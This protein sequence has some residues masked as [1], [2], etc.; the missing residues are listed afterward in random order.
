MGCPDE[1]TLSDFLVGLLPEARRQ[2]VLAHVEGC[3]SCQ[4]A[5][6]AGGD[7]TPTAGVPDV[8]SS[9][10]SE[11]LA[12]GATLSRYV[13]QERLGSGAM[14]VVY[15]AYDPELDRQVAL[16]LLRPEGRGVE[17]LRLRLL[18]E[19]QALARLSHPH[20]VAVHDVGMCGDGVFLALE[21]VDGTTLADWL[22]EPRPWREVLRVFLDAGRGLAAAHAAGL[23][24]RDFKPANVLV[25]RDG[26]ARVTDFGLA[27]PA[28]RAGVLPETSS[29]QVPVPEED[30]LGLLTRTGALLGTPAYMAP[31]QLEGHGVDALSD[32][33]SF[34]V[35]LYEA[36][37]G[38]RPFDG[39]SL[40]ELGQAAREGRVK[41][42]GRDSKVPARVRN[43][44]LRGL[45]PRPEDRFPSMEAL[46]VALTPAPSRVRTW[47]AVSAATACLVGVAMGY[48]VAHRREARCAQEAEKLDAAWGAGRRERVRAAFLATKK[49]YAADAWEK[50]ST[51]LDAHA[52]L[53]RSLRT[54]SCLVADEGASGPASRLAWQ[55]AACLDARLWQ[56]AAVTEVL[57][58]ADAQTVQN[59]PQLVASL[60]G[61]AGCRDAPAS[62]TR[63][64]PPELL[65]P[66]VDAARRKLAE[67]RAL[68]EAGRHAEGNEM[69]SALLQEVDA[70]DYRPLEAEVLLLRG[71]LHGHLGKAK[72]AEDILYRALWAAEAGRDDETVARV[73][74]LLV[75]IVGDQMARVGEAD[76]LAQHARAVVERL[77][78]ERFPAIATDLHLRLGGVRLVQGKLEQA[79]E[80]LTQGL[81][82]A[83]KTYGPDSL[84]TSYFLS[85]L[86][87]VR[88]RQNRTVEALALYRQAQELRERLW[89]SE[90]PA[91][92]LNLSNLATELLSLG[93]REEAVAAWRRALALLEASRPPDH[94][95]LGPPLN[96]LG[97]AL[98]DQGRLDEARQYLKRA[99]AIFE[100]SKG[101]NHPNTATTLSGLGMVAYDSQNLDEALG[102]QRQALERIQSALGPDSPRAA[103][104]LMY[105]GV[106]QHRMGHHDEARRHLLRALHLWEKEN[107]PDSATV[108]NALRPLARLELSAGAPQKALAYCKRALG[109]DE[110]AQGTETPDVAMDLACVAEAHLALGDPEQAVPLLERARLLNAKAPRDPLDEAWVSFLLARALGEREPAVELARAA[111]LA[112]EA[113]VRM[114]AL[115]TRARLELKEVTAWQERHPAPS[116]V[117]RKAV[118]P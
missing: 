91:L 112:E 106:V 81:E 88:S 92:A 48:V 5:L 30:S 36:L 78:R 64:Q 56:F 18:R 71:Q 66:R 28:S 27:R 87:R 43:A 94:A 77:G 70:L 9:G 2:E 72:E 25:G 7:S 45:R 82:L 23:V 42:P 57:E 41:A 15:A 29:A 102:Y 49:P 16:K 104:P 113:R 59:V 103:A 13:V 73:W 24:H 75:W 65:R 109:N 44:V 54:E 17:E 31:E 118:T 101:P 100:R 52:S 22:K 51:A 98:R 10:S 96:N 93:R 14:G 39:L 19:A 55:T 116:S 62:S 58:K 6:A 38:V 63:P 117:A 99:L 33:F 40:Q 90:H 115:G 110:R 85:S 21:L 83:R 97:S 111:A 37:H 95:S 74:V 61:L 76:R 69:T 8:S 32:Q 89:G 67:A 26:R 60:E 68:M 20:V 3:A 84:R 86:G 1:T 46:L 105:L 80:E 4:R 107:G 53:W 34:C 12:R 35:A 11:P 108:N 50:L 114:T 79:D 47:V